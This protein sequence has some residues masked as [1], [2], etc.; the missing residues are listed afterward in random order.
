MAKQTKPNSTPRVPEFDHY[1]LSRKKDSYTTLI[2]KYAQLQKRPWGEASIVEG[3]Y[4]IAHL[5][6]I[7][8]PIPSREQA[9]ATVY[10]KQEESDYFNTEVITEFLMGA[11]Y[12]KH[13]CGPAIEMKSLLGKSI[14]IIKVEKYMKDRKQ[15]S[16]IT[17]ELTE[18]KSYMSDDIIMDLYYLSDEDKEVLLDE[19]IENEMLESDTFL[20]QPKNN[21]DAEN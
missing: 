7:E 4:F 17:W 6:S 1:T 19:Q 3:Y 16:S 12:N 9:I 20:V 5:E 15:I 13:S 10:W 2:S 21:E 8:S 18:E 14:H 11:L